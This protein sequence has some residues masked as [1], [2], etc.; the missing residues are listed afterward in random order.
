[1]QKTFFCFIFLISTLG[2]SQKNLDQLL[3]RYNSGNIPY[4]HVDELKSYPDNIILLD[5]R[6]QREYATSH[7]K[8]AIA[9]GYDFFNIDSTSQKIPNKNSKIVVYCS[10]GIR[11]E[12]IAEKLKKSGYKNVFNLYGG[13]FEW[14][15]NQQKVYNLKEQETDSVHAFSKDW[16]KWLQKGIKVY[17]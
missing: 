9:V 10:L 15:N 4:I 11:S 17:E 14:K 13:I 16:S 8:D 12:D 7:L 1:M 5:A 6:E 2:Y 3:K